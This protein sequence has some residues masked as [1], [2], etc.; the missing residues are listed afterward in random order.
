MT[1]QVTQIIEDY[2]SQVTLERRYSEH[3][4]RAYRHDLEEFQNYLR[5]RGVEDPEGLDATLLRGF[6]SSLLKK[7]RKVTVGRKVAVLRSCFKFAQRKG[8]I[9]ENPAVHLRAPKLEKHI[10]PFLSE[11]EAEHLLRPLPDQTWLIRRDQAIGELFYASGIR[12]SELA[13]LNWTD[14][15][16]SI[17]MVRV[18]GKG[19]RERIV[20]LGRVAIEALR[21]YQRAVEQAGRDSG[22][23]VKEAQAV[24]LNRS[25]EPADRSDHCPALEEKG[26]AVRAV[27]DHQPPC[28]AAQ[29]CHPPAQCRGGPAGGSG[30]AGSPKLIDH[31]KIHPYQSGASDGGV[32]K[33]VSRGLNKRFALRGGLNHAD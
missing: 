33:I 32:Q 10:P 14:I 27:V 25:G 1:K 24:F 16:F 18:L 8:W 21:E 7:N 26:S 15:D 29:F 5:E 28:P 11:K 9:L 13:G 2:M 31:P 12:L 22:L 17:R 4:L 3:S 20:P 6:L 23:K 30:V 19:G